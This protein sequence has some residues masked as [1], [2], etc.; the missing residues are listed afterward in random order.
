MPNGFS[1]VGYGIGLPLGSVYTEELTIK[2]YNLRES[3]FMDTLDDKWSV[4]GW[5]MLIPFWIDIALLFQFV[6]S[7][8]KHFSQEIKKNWT[9]HP[10]LIDAPIWR[11]LFDKVRLNSILYPTCF[12]YSFHSVVRISMNIYMYKQMQITLPKI[13]GVVVYGESLLPSIRYTCPHYCTDIFKS[14]CSRL[15]QTIKFMLRTCHT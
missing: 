14:H 9:N 3:G 5:L 4:F 6:A 1:N 11:I 13:L 12:L 7:I 15:N 2:I 8:A 10:S